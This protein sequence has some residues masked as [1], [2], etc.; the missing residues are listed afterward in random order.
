LIPSFPTSLILQGW[1]AAAA[2]C[3]AMFIWLVRRAAPY[4]TA[5]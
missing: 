2:I 1:T 4:M 5:S 3:F